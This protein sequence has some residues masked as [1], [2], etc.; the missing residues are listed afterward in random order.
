MNKPVR[1]ISNWRLGQA[2][3]VVA[4]QRVATRQGR[5]RRERLSREQSSSGK[6]RGSPLL[7]Y[8]AKLLVAALALCGE[9]HGQSYT[10]EKLVPPAGV[11]ETAPEF[12]TN[13]GR[14]FGGRSTPFEFLP[15]RRPRV[16]TALES[17]GPEYG[18]V[19]ATDEGTL[20]AMGFNHNDADQET[21]ALY[22]L[23]KGDSRVRVF[24]PPLGEEG[25]YRWDDIYSVFVG[26]NGDLHGRVSINL[27][28]QSDDHSERFLFATYRYQVSTGRV[29]VDLT[30]DLLAR[31]RAGMEVVGP[32][33]R[34]D[35]GW[36]FAVDI[37]TSVIP[38]KEPKALGSLD[39]AR[40]RMNEAGDVVFGGSGTNCYLWRAG[41]YDR[42]PIALGDGTRCNARAI[43]AGHILLS[44]GGEDE[45]REW[46]VYELG[47][48]TPISV[49]DGVEEL[50]PFRFIDLTAM[51][52]RGQIVG[53]G[54]RD[55]GD[56]PSVQFLLNPRL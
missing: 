55:E 34:S 20:V 24:N 1:E 37:R 42:R 52:D 35:E 25:G 10:F 21:Q 26:S 9:A 38:L 14:I 33:R 3:D 32:S 51:N 29:S 40:F 31:N 54:S 30:R 43:T 36:N 6:L 19:A 39:G 16:I 49:V 44:L 45:P 41:E 5:C 53:V 13:T 28:R 48:Q 11:G 50:R 7:T 27:P 22:V 8:P 15:G 56:S 18:L 17:F 12:L 4:R 2:D 47:G 23:R 46:I